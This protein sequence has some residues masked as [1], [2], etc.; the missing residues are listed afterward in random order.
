MTTP[1]PVTLPGDEDLS[2]A[3]RNLLGNAVTGCLTDLRDGDAE[4]DDPAKE[5]PGMPA[6]RCGQ[7][8]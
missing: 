2:A 4:H 8:C 6:D 3:E 1:S 5:R 7:N